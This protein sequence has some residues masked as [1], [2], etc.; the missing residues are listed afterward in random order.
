MS[1]YYIFGGRLLRYDPENRLH[2]F[3]RSL[4]ITVTSLTLL[5]LFWWVSALSLDITFLPTPLRVYEAFWRLIEVG[6]VATGLTLQ[7]HIVSSLRRF[8]GGFIIAFVVAVPLGLVMGYSRMAEELTNPVI[9]VL[10]PIAPMAW[11]P[12]FILA[13]GVV[14]GPMMVVFVGVFFPLLS[15]TVFGVKKID[16][17]MIDAARTLGANGLQ[18]FYKVMLPCTVPYIMNGVKIGLGIGWMCIVAAE[19]IM[20][21]GGGVGYF[22][23]NNAAQ[24]GN[25]PNVFV[26]LIIISFLGIITTGIAERAHKIIVSRM[27]ME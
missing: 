23:L 4:G 17:Y 11:A 16:T 9:E 21:K 7:D 10:R 6:D 5:V 1:E 25:W 12:L 24:V 8:A 26:G 18:T 2:R 15:N 13:L 14:T 20:A 22:I 27:G 3:V 19:M